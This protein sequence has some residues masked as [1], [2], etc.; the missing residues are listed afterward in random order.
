MK[1]PAVSRSPRSRPNSSARSGSEYSPIPNSAAIRSR[2]AARTASRPRSVISA[3]RPR[4]SSGFGRRITMPCASSRSIVFVTLVGCTMSRSP[5]TRSGSEPARLND[6]STSASYL[7]NVSPYG[8]RIASSSPSRICW[9]RMIEATAA[10]A[11]DG[12]NL[13][14]QIRAARSMGSK[15][16]SS[17]FRTPDTLRTSSKGTE[18]GAAGGR[19][20]FTNR[21][22]P[23]NCARI[24]TSWCFIA[25]LEPPCHPGHGC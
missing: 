23:V 11:E 16:N 25:V 6:S 12:P 21:Q 20:S 1:S 17:A 2:V 10:I 5:M 3:S 8:R 15:G 4:P 24:I 18:Q 14:S 22:S 9:A 7:A 19:A 13:C